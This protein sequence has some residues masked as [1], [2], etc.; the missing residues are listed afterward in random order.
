MTLGWKADKEKACV[1][2][3]AEGS[4]EWILSCGLNQLEKALPFADGGGQGTERLGR[5]IECSVK[6]LGLHHTL[7]IHEKLFSR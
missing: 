3:D 6:L 5:E 1:R 2:E 7:D 4:R